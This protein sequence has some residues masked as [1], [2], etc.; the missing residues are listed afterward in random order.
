MRKTFARYVS[1]GSGC[2]P[3]QTTS[4]GPLGRDDG[5]HDACRSVHG[6]L[7]SVVYGM[8]STVVHLSDLSEELRAFVATM[9]SARRAQALVDAADGC[10]SEVRFMLGYLEEERVLETLRA[11]GLRVPRPERLVFSSPRYVPRMGEPGYEH[12]RER[13]HGRTR[14]GF[15]AANERASDA[16]LRAISLAVSEHLLRVAATGRDF[17]ALYYPVGYPLELR[18]ARNLLFYKVK[19]SESLMTDHV[20]RI[21]KCAWMSATGAEDPD[22]MCLDWGWAPALEDA[23]R[24]VG[25]DEF[26][27]YS[28]GPFEPLPRARREPDDHPRYAFWMG[29][30]LLFG[31]P[32][33][34]F[35]EAEAARGEGGPLPEWARLRDRAAGVP[36]RRRHARARPGRA[37]YL[38]N[39]T[40]PP[41][42]DPLRV[43]GAAAQRTAAAAARRPAR[44]ARPQ[45]IPPA[46]TRW[47][48][49][50]AE[51]RRAPSPL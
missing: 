31:D 12:E 13:W 10:D 9:R 6:Q 11:L 46:S 4:C 8:L 51:A 42:T 7:V 3:S 32:V 36:R 37:I 48:G 44:A 29:M 35:R 28:V 40:D 41:N 47:R 33:E 45:R 39:K 14:R 24:A 26:A 34:D 50:A 17:P 22:F 23:R 5:G 38:H 16:S 25:Y 1:W 18:R 20:C 15:A 19:Y 30:R 27:D 2:A 21:A 49:R 43:E